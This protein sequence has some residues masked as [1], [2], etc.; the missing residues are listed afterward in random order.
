MNIAQEWRFSTSCFPA[1]EREDRWRTALDGIFARGDLSI[2]DSA[3]FRGDIYARRGRDGFLIAGISAGRCEISHRR[4]HVAAVED[5]LLIL[6]V[7]KG[8]G[9]V[10]QADIDLPF[11]AGDLV[12]RQ[13]SLP[14]QVRFATPCEGAVFK[15]PRAR[16]QAYAAAPHTIPP[17]RIDHTVGLAAAAVSM[18]GGVVRQL[19]RL[20]SGS[21]ASVE[22]ATLE[23]LAP[24]IRAARGPASVKRSGTLQWG[25][26][27]RLVERELTNPNLSVAHLARAMGVSSRH[28]YAS[29]AAYGQRFRQYLLEKRLER[30]RAVLADP[31]QAHLTLTSICFQGGFSDFSHFSRAFKARYG[32]SPRAYRREIR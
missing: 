7:F 26:I 6:C 27:E 25:R 24:P 30:C 8:A 10:R 3:T 20:D 29:F 21:I 5:G 1:A 14:S 18:L 4:E 22:N 16:A 12:V 11:R 2:A 13:A 9:V 32:R 17:F 23:L 19:A 28:V 15:V 31:R